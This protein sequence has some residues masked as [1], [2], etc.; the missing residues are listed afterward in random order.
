MATIENYRVSAEQRSVERW[1]D[2]QDNEAPVSSKEEDENRNHRLDSLPM[3]KLKRQLLSWYFEEREKQ[4]INRYQMAIDQDFYDSI[5]WSE[6]D[7]ADVESRGQHPLVFNEVAPMVDW[8]I[9]TQRRTRVDWAVLPRGPSD[10]QAA[11]VKTQ[12]LKYVSDIN[13]V[14]WARSRAFDDAVKVGIGWLDDGARNDPTK[15]ILFSRYENWRN[16]LHDSCAQELDLEDGRYIFRWRWVDLDVAIAMF[17]DRKHV[18][19]KAAV[20]HQLYGNDDDELYYLNQHFSAKDG[21]GR[22]VGSRTYTGDAF[23]VGTRR[24]RVKLIQGWYKVPSKV[25]VLRGEA[26]DGEIYDQKNPQQAHAVKTKVCEIVDAIMMRMHY[27]LM[28]EGDLLAHGPSPYK[29]QRFPLT[30]LWCYRR[31][32]DGMPYGAIRRVRDIQEDMNKRA[33][34]SQFVLSTNQLI[35]EEG[36]FE[37]WDLA[38]EEADR[39]DGV[40]VYKKGREVEIRRDSEMA[41]GHMEMFQLN[42]M[43]IQQT[44]GVNNE[45]QGRQSNANMSGEAIR[46][47]QQ[48]GSVQTTQIFDNQRLAIQIQGEKQ[49]SNIEQFYTEP[50]VIRITEAKGR[51]DWV[52][53]NQ[54]ETQADG[55]VRWINDVTASQADFI[56]AEQDYQGTMRQ[57]MF[58]NMMNVVAK[59]PPEIA[60]RFMRIAFEFA[61]FPNKDE[62]VAEIRKITGEPDP[63]KKLSPEEMQELEAQR[64][65]QQAM[66]EQQ[67]RAIEAEIAEKVAKAKKANA[68][69]EKVMA[70]IEALGADGN[71]EEFRK[72][73]EQVRKAQQQAAREVEQA[74]Q[75]AVQLQHELNKSKLMLTDRSLEIQKDADTKLAVARI[76]ADA[77]IRGDEK[78]AEVQAEANE[79]SAELQQKQML[80]KPPKPAGQSAGKPKAKAKPR[81]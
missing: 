75:K 33:S 29:H 34:K 12:V 19:K 36:A 68:E 14:P 58:E 71:S 54:P 41:K 10:V 45:N 62:I 13:K 69:A 44:G 1:L 6:E 46:A 8:I 27:A 38:R 2:E 51:I 17:P 9:G 70:E 49:L 56:V 18:L 65:Q 40:L 25:Q 20:A 22:A 73:E 24:A 16:V 67:Q 32:R 50:K 31:G 28:T 37:D 48:Q 42:A 77:K 64:A 23:M 78:R 80:M 43:K 15:D 79:R 53:I 72:L 74:T 30:P 7:A 5:Q 3:Q 81:K 4:S 26:Y 66:M 61:D 35:A 47:L 21:Q 59:M 63:N 76:A 52:K 11:H 55:T 57:A 60:V 39:P